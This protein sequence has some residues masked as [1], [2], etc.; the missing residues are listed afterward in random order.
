[1]NRARQSVKMLM[2]TYFQLLALLNPGNPNAGAGFL[3]SLRGPLLIVV[4]ALG[5]ALTIAMVILVMHRDGGG[6]R[7]KQRSGARLTT[8]KSTSSGEED[9]QRKKRRRHKRRRREH[10]KRN[11]TLS[12]TGGLPPRGSNT[13][14]EEDAKPDR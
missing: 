3:D 2:N 12:E 11:P 8:S 14:K 4:I 6:T 9:V 10:R 7:Y 5:L 13:S 1:M